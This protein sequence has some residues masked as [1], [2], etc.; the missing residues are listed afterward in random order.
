MTKH[1]QDKTKTVNS[2]LYVQ[3]SGNKLKYYYMNQIKYMLREENEI[4]LTSMLML[5]LFSSPSC[6][7]F[8]GRRLGVSQTTVEKLG[9]QII[10]S[11]V[12][13]SDVDVF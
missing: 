5:V 3:D 8:P 12:A 9:F 13:I 2:H 10:V 4:L 1:I 11:S 7:C 6:M